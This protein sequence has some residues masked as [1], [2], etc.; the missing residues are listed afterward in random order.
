MYLPHHLAMVWDG[1]TE[2]DRRQQFLIAVFRTI[3]LA[4]GTYYIGIELLV[5]IG[6]VLLLDQV[7]DPIHRLFSIR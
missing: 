1:L 2:Y 5:G 3:V 6:A 7:T 4:V